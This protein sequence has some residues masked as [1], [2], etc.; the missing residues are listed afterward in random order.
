MSCTCSTSRLDGG[1]L[2]DQPPPVSSAG[3]RFFI[4][5]P[6]FFFIFS[7]DREA[8]TTSESSLMHIILQILLKIVL[9][10]HVGDL[11][12]LDGITKEKWPLDDGTRI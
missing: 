9:W 11:W 12:P 10:Q 4:V 8:H 2:D 6:H 7:V 3:F 5:V 1:Y